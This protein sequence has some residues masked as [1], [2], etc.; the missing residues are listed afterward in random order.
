MN[1]RRLLSLLVV[2]ILT[3]IPSVFLTGCES[4]DSPKTEGVDSYFED[5]PFISDPRDPTSSRIVSIDPASAEV[6]FS[7]QQV[8]FTAN[9]GR[10]PYNWDTADSSK[11]TVDVRPGTEAAVY[12]AD[13][14]GPNDV[15]VYDQDGH[16]AVAPINGPTM[17]LVATANPGEIKVDG[18][19]SVLTASGGVPPYHWDVGDIAL[20][21]VSPHDGGSV[22]Y[23][24]AH[25]PDNSAIVQDA[26]GNRYTLVIKQP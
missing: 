2:A 19:L 17:P 20:G 14:V 4:D 6:S 10:T 8:V 13:V 21:D 24:R 3:L 7:G 11:G 16:A 22:V 12:T 18:G 15:I 26:A 1:T 9:G 5:H 23:T 25:N